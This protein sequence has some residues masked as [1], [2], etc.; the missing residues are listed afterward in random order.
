ML[1]IEHL[2]VKV[3][4]MLAFVRSSTGL[5]DGEYQRKLRQRSPLKKR[6]AMN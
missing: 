5:T 1:R 2:P 3:E 6:P 4:A